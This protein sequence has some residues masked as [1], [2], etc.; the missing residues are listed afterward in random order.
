V[1]GAHDVEGQVAVTVEAEEPSDL[2]AVV[3]AG[4]ADEGLDQEQGR[5]GQEEPGGG[6]LR[7]GE[8]YPVGRPERQLLLVA[9]VP[10]EPVPPA[11][12]RKQRPD[13]GQEGDE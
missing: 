8:G 3:L 10:P 4:H 13:A 1:P 9:A 6:F 2:G 11:E 7:R 5:H 12:H